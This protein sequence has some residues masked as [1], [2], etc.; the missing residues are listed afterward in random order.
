MLI[1]FLQRIVSSS[2]VF[3]RGERG[4]V[5]SPFNPHHD[6]VV[7]LKN[8]SNPKKLEYFGDNQSEI[9]NNK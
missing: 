7:L 8:V 6:A 4:E 1:L 3:G 9:S 2:P 5:L